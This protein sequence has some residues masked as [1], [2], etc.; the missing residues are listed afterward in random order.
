M[1]KI[2][3]RDINFEKLKR[4]QQ[5]GS[6]SI[7]Y[8]DGTFCYKI[9]TDYDDSEKQMVYEKFFYMENLKLDNVLLPKGM[10]VEDGILQGYIM[11]Y[12]QNSTTLLSRFTRREF[13]CKE[14]FEYVYKASIVL[15][16][17]H[18]NG[19][20]WQ[21]L[22]FENILV[23]DNK[24][25][26]FCDI[27]GCSYNEITTP[28]CSVLLTNFMLKF[29]K[30]KVKD[31]KELDKLSMILSF[32]YTLY[33]QILQRITKKQYHA[34]SDHISTLET[35]RPIAN[36]LVDKNRPIEKLPYLDEVINLSD[37]FEIDRKKVMTLRQM[38]FK[39]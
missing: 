24:N 35:L 13:N 14:L 16:N 20:A 22:S 12:F 36:M 34:L 11:D 8:T 23:D 4:L 5:Q 28:Y 30:S 2:N 29:R 7:V 21:D 19:V 10:I 26:M 6:K 1:E 17:I 3:L 39:I 25:V 27:D 9:L 37:D 18:S 38:I 31:F 15:K 32:Y 33:F